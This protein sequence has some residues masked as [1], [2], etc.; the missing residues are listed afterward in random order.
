MPKFR[1]ITHL[2]VVFIY[3][4]WCLEWAKIPRSDKIL[5]L[6]SVWSGTHISS[7]WSDHAQE[8]L[9]S[10]VSNL[11]DQIQ[12]HIQL[13]IRTK[14]YQAVWIFYYTDIQKP[15]ALDRPHNS[16]KLHVCLSFQWKENTRQLP[17][18]FVSLLFFVI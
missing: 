9:G 6:F 15:A 14:T 4:C 12:G 5:S 18:I 7:V 2:L 16:L 8:E 10:S 1:W 17:F 3:F 13:F 11:S